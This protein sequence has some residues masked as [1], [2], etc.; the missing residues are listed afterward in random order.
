MAIAVHIENTRN[1]DA[2]T[3]YEAGWEQLNERGARDPVG[4]QSHTAWIVGDVLHVLGVW[5]SQEHLDAGM[6]IIANWSDQ[7]LS[8]RAVPALTLQ[9]K[10]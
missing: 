2:R 5:N 4:R 3:A 10:R 6:Q 8:G 9:R 1:T 7:R